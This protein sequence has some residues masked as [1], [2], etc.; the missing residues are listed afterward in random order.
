MGTQD[1]VDEVRG[2]ACEPQSYLE[3]MLGS[4][5]GGEGGGLG[6]GATIPVVA[7]V[8]TWRRDGLGGKG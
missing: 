7:G 5:N 4:L 1:A 3:G 2:D 6:T 8:I